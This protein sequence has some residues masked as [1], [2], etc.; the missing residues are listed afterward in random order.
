MALGEGGG[1]YAAGTGHGSPLPTVARMAA[2]G[3]C[4]TVEFTT[5]AVEQRIRESRK[6]DFDEEKL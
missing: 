5:E 6:D 1:L 2:N 3:N 4:W